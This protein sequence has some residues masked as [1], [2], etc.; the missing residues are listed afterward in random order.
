MYLIILIL[1]DWLT[2]LEPDLGLD[3]DIANVH[4]K[5]TQ[6]KRFTFVQEFALGKGTDMA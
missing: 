6:S 5:P 1:N 4:H 3:W 2:Y